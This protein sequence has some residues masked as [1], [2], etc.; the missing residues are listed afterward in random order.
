MRVT[1]TKVFAGQVIFQM[2]TR[3]KQVVDDNKDKNRTSSKKKKAGIDTVL[4]QLAGPSK[5]NAVQKTSNDREQF[6]RNLTSNC[7]MIRKRKHNV[8]EGCVPGQTKISQTGGSEKIQTQER[9][10]RA[11]EGKEENQLDI[12]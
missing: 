5:I 7:K 6:K 1:E 9:R 2:M 4:A 11:R 3:K 12:M 8:R 10:M